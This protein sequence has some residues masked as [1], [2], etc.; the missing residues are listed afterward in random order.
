[1]L[2]IVTN[3]V[4]SPGM[5]FY[6]FLRGCVRIRILSLYATHAIVRQLLDLS[7]LSLLRMLLP[8][9]L[10]ASN[11]LY[12]VMIRLVSSTQSFADR[13]HNMIIFSK[14]ETFLENQFT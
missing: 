2:V 12:D 13:G 7:I 14:N 4:S 6:F 11:W 5:A 9:F 3:T 1:M 10:L 8:I